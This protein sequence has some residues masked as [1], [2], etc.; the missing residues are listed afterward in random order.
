MSPGLLMYPDAA[1]H[2]ITRRLRAADDDRRGRLARRQSRS[3]RRAG[4]RAETMRR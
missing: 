1:H 4:A 2:E 3:S